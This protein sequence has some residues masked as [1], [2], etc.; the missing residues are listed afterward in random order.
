MPA[1][2][3]LSMKSPQAARPPRRQ[4]GGGSDRATKKEQLK[5]LAETADDTVIPFPDLLIF[6]TFCRI[7]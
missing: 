5:Q 3:A 2:V 1:E 4:G 6:A 7:L